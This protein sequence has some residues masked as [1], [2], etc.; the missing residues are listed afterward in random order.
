M[1]KQVNYTIESQEPGETRWFHEGYKDTQRAAMLLA[2]RIEAKGYRVR[3]IEREPDHIFVKKG[4]NVERVNKVKE[5]PN[6]IPEWQVSVLCEKCGCRGGQHRAT[7]GMCPPL[8]SWGRAVSD[9]ADE[10]NIP[11]RDLDNAYD[12]YWKQSTFFTP[13]R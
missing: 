1:P 4:K 13:K 7:D 8:N 12:I 11:D 9:P 6:V 2:K 5:L 10:W 3:I